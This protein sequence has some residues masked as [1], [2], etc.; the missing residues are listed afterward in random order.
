LI[1]II[2]K[3]LKANNTKSL[4]NSIL[5]VFKLIDFNHPIGKLSTIPQINVLDVIQGPKPKRPKYLGYASEDCVRYA[6]WRHV[7]D[8]APCTKILGGKGAVKSWLIKNNCYNPVVPKI[9]RRNDPKFAVK[10]ERIR[11]KFNNNCQAIADHLGIDP[12]AIVFCAKRDGWFNRESR[13]FVWK[14]LENV[15]DNVIVDFT[16]YKHTIRHY[17]RQ[18]ALKYKHLIKGGE[19]LYQKGYC[20]DHRL[21]IYEGWHR[22]SKIVPWQLLCHPSNLVVISQDRNSCKRHNS[23]FG[24]KIL[25]KRIQKFNRKYGAVLLP[26][27]DLQSKGRHHSLE[28]SRKRKSK[29]IAH[30]IAINSLGRI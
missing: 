25:L 17:T 7:I 2:N 3:D 20:L 24:P 18:L 28:F 14:D 16:K 22:G 12:D 8:R 15:P 26:V 29:D 27:E 13:K 19:N 10:L 6:I 30:R 4:R 21:T 9:D 1:D 5:G 23:D 11:H